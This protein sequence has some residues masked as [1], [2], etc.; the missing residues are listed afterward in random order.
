MKR[1][2]FTKLTIKNFLSVGN[3]P[4]TVNFKSGMNIIRGI[5]RDEEDIFNGCGKSSVISAFY[6][7]I[8]GEAL[9]ELPNKF[10]IN[11]KIGKGAVVRLEFED[12]SSKRGEEYFVIER[13]LGPNKCRVW[14]N[15]IEK[16]KSSIAET[17]KYILE[18]LSADEEIFKNCIVMRA[19]SG[20]SFMTKKK[21]EK[22][23]FIESIFNLGVFS[24]MLKLVKDDIKEVRSKFDI[25]NSALSVMNE[26]AERYK[27]KIAE[28][29][30]QIE[31]QQ[32][33]IAIEKQRLEDC[34]K[35][36]EEKIALMEQN[37][38]EFDP[39]VLNKQMEN[40][41]KANEYDKDLTTKIG[42]CN[43]ELKA[44]KK[45]I[46]DIDKIGNACPTCKR[47]YDEGYVNDNAKMKAELMEKAKTVY[48]TW[49]ETD[50][51]QKKL[52]DY[53]TN[54]QKI[55]DQQKRLE[56]EIKV[57]KVRINSA[58]TSINQFRQMIEKV[59]EKYAISPIDAFVQSLAETEQQ[60][61]EKRSTVDEIQKQL[62][63]MNVCEH[64]LGEQGVR[65]YI[66]HMLLELLNGRIKYYLKSFKS[67]FEFTFNEVFEEVIKDAH[68]VMCMYNNCSGAEMKKIDLAIAF[69]FLDIIKFHRQVEY[70][71]AFYDEILDS[72]VDNKS[73]E[74]IIDFIAEKAANNGKS[75]YIVT[76]K[77]DIM[78]PQLTETVLLEK[79][80][81]F[82]RR[83]EA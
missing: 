42:G 40:L 8:F 48:A 3:E 66:V 78:M 41:R 60:C 12:I 17:N 47:A 80:N 19:N 35:K 16:T 34:I 43:Y 30:K 21:T 83:I 77:T 20:A 61:D 24:E 31:E 13:T 81:G 72:S 5:N 7:A 2:N 9:V 68:G 73:L 82:T 53:K 6:F 57:N 46:S 25:E 64:I 49:K 23:N 54:I 1:I 45:Q 4:V 69:S 15:D 58:K 11:R 44:L 37:N 55:I 28:I 59:E 14:K 29:Q 62:G 56:N 76:H 18:V 51:N 26:T 33:K 39:S 27:T 52:A 38:A 74:H 67:T 32:Q 71:I 22:K 36:E 75:I 10:L 79:R 50:A 63:Q 65:S 70:N